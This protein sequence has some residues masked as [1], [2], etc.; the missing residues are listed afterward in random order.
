MQSSAWPPR[1]WW[2]SEARVR[3]GHRPGWLGWKSRPPCSLPRHAFADE[4]A[5]QALQQARAARAGLHDL[6]CTATHFVARNIAL[7]MRRYLPAGKPVDR[8]LLSG[9]GVRP[10]VVLGQ[11]DRNGA[12][13]LHGRV[14]TPADLCATVYHCLGID[15]RAEMRDLGGRPMPLA[16]GEPIGEVL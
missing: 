1:S 6:L 10:G 14:C 9:G 16:R 7:A 11:S 4:F 5:Q 13:P 12:Y 15:H 8:V 3:P 2:D